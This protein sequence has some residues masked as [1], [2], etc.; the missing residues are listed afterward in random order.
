MRER[1]T[2]T[3]AKKVI[4]FINS[5]PLVQGI[6]DE[7]IALLEEIRSKDFLKRIANNGNLKLVEV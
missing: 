6:T 3:S 2:K 1:K 4:R 7:D 5:F